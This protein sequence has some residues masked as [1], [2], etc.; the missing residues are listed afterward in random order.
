[1]SLS[2]GATA[3]FTVGGLSRKDPQVPHLLEPGDAVIF[4][5]SKRLVY[6]GVTRL[7]PG[8]TPPGL[9]LPEPGRLNFTFRVL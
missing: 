8:T 4:G 1:V 3:V 6:H 5:R 7:L 9:G 2:V